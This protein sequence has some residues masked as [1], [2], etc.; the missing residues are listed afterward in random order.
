MLAYIPPKGM[1]RNQKLRMRALFLKC[2]GDECRTEFNTVIFLEKICDMECIELDG[3]LCGITKND[4]CVGALKRDE[5]AVAVAVVAIAG[6]F[7]VVAVVT[8]VVGISSI[9]C[10]CERS[11]QEIIKRER[12]KMAE[13]N[14]FNNNND[15]LYEA[16]DNEGVNPMYTDKETVKN[17]KWVWEG[18]KKN[19]YSKPIFKYH[20]TK[21]KI[22]FLTG[23]LSFI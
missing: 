6:I 20:K 8:V 16:N 1:P 4:I 18:K 17:T 13:D 7:I 2:E 23:P 10:V 12:A 5:S 14:D 9:V 11:H 19:K 22:L 21:Q 3:D 15:P